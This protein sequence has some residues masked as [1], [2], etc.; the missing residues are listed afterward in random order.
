MRNTVLLV[1]VAFLFPTISF[2]AFAMPVIFDTKQR[3]SLPFNLNERA[4]VHVT[5]RNVDFNSA[6]SVSND[7]L[8]NYEY[9]VTLKVLDSTHRLKLKLPGLKLD[10]FQ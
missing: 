7:I 5:K 10:F 2:R 4:E 8:D 3:T 9:D 1:Y 6:E